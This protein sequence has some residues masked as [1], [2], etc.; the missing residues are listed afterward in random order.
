MINV[1]D[2][3]AMCLRIQVIPQNDSS[4]YRCAADIT[5][6]FG[7]HWRLARQCVAAQST[8]QLTIPLK[9]TERY[10]NQNTSRLCRVNRIMLEQ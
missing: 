9:Y 4:N 6:I 7:C 5:N 10:V 2:A 3:F 1:L 8:I